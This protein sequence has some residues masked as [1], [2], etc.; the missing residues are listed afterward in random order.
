MCEGGMEGL[1][2][3]DG[4]VSWFAPAL[5]PCKSAYQWLQPHPRTPCDHRNP[6]LFALSVTCSLTI[7]SK[8]AL[9]PSRWRRP[10]FRLGPRN[11]AMIFLRL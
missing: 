6:G 3:D 8:T 9:R 10:Q 7:D 1:R 2:G 11:K 5:A 4:V